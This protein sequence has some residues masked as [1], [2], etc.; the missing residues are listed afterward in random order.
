MSG[1]RANNSAT[2]LT[3]LLFMFSLIFLSL[4]I[5]ADEVDFNLIYDIFIICVL[6]LV[7]SIGYIYVSKQFKA[8]YLGVVTMITILL[9]LVINT[10]M[11]LQIILIFFFI[12]N[13]IYIIFYLGIYTACIDQANELGIISDEY[14]RDFNTT[15]SSGEENG[16]YLLK[17]A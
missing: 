12:A 2:R 10:N 4:G 7:I 14:I 17:E 8:H 5:L 16:G 11:I 1:D 9:A 6:S 13:I 15:T 3:S